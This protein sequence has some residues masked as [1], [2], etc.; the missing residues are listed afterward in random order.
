[1]T[2]M[3]QYQGLA[4]E[5]LITEWHK[6]TPPNINPEDLEIG[7]ELFVQAALDKIAKKQSTQKMAALNLSEKKLPEEAPDQVI[8]KIKAYVKDKAWYFKRACESGFPFSLLERSASMASLKHM[9]KHFDSMVAHF[10]LQD[11]AVWLTEQ[12]LDARFKDPFKRLQTREITQC[13]S[14][15]NRKL[16]KDGDKRAGYYLLWLIKQSTG[17]AFEIPPKDSFA[18]EMVMQVLSNFVASKSPLQIPH[19]LVEILL[20][21]SSRLDNPLYKLVL[22]SEQWNTFLNFALQCLKSTI[23]DVWPAKTKVI[24]DFLEYM[25][26]KNK[27]VIANQLSS[28]NDEL[29]AKIGSHVLKGL[30]AATLREAIPHFTALIEL[31]PHINDSHIEIIFGRPFVAFRQDATHY[32][33]DDPSFTR[34]L[35]FNDARKVF[36]E[37]DLM[38]GVYDTRTT[39]GGRGVPAHLLA[40]DMT[41]EKMAWGIAL[42]P[43]MGTDLSI[44]TAATPSTFGLPRMGPARYALQ[45]CGEFITLQFRGTN[46]VYYINAK[47]EK[48]LQN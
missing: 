22:H 2:P 21:T 25:D 34:R 39:F 35:N 30:Q 47:T 15:L 12:E 31:L 16:S 13:C 44:H 48:S 10:M 4:R 18:P 9:L 3:T 7:V 1:M 28:S 24:T 40:Y 32:Y 6:G 29:T 45:R 33:K 23:S 19:L 36:I 17:A 26:E 38:I 46:D 5:V 8:E 37:G 27:K 20:F 14:D 42:N 41:T 11:E 43:T